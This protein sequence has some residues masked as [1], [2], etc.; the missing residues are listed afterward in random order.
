M[1]YIET[2][3]TTPTHIPLYPYAPAGH[4]TP[5]ANPQVREFPGGRIV[6]M[7][8]GGADNNAYLVQCATSGR[9]LLIDAANDADHII[10]LIKQEANGALDLIVTTHQHVDHWWALPD[11]AAAFECSTAAHELDA[12]ALPVPPDQLLEDGDTVSVGELQMT[13]SHLAGHTPGAIALT[14]HDRGGNTHI[15]TGDSLF[16]GGVGKTPDEEAFKTLF[17]DV[18]TKLFE[19]NADSAIVYP[20][21]GDDTTLGAERPSLD[22]WR[23]RGW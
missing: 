16:P 10:N 13:V 5:N 9:A 4:I 17:Q 12:T 7:S 19:P 14:L 2:M 6:K 3:N 18:M 23:A 1:G 21:H 22:E 11:V 15:F 8:V 20:G